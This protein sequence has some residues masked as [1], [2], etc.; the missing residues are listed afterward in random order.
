VKIATNGTTQTKLVPGT[1]HEAWNRYQQ[2]T[3][4][5]VEASA[6]QSLYEFMVHPWFTWMEQMG[7]NPQ[8]EILLVQR[9]LLVQHYHDGRTPT[10]TTTTTTTTGNNRNNTSATD[11]HEALVQEYQRILQRLGLAPHVPPE[12]T[13]QQI[14]ARQGEHIWIEQIDKKLRKQLRNFFKPYN[15]RFDQF[16]QSYYHTDG[17]T[18]T[19][20]SLLHWNPALWQ[21]S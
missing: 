8:T 18:A 9:E 5:A 16:L 11:P 7:R 1:N 20:N 19:N 12:A 21:V 4:T 2:L 13:V 15:E 17:L 10:T 6:G 14:L 3:P